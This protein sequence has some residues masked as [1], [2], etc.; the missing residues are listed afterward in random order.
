MNFFNLKTEIK[1]KYVDIFSLKRY[2]NNNDIDILDDILLINTLPL[3]KQDCLIM[4]TLTAENEII[5]IQK[6]QDNY[7]YNK[8]IIV[9]GMNCIDN[10]VD[11][12]YEQ[13]LNLGFNETYIYKGGMFEWVL[14]QDIY[15]EEYFRTTMKILDPLEWCNNEYIKNNLLTY[16]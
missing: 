15:G 10:T 6:L 14:L 5:E 16:Y 1:K 4:K 7:I 3:N 12:K 2:I 13:L 9:Y 11:N 8:K